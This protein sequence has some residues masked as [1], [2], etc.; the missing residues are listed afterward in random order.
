MVDLSSSSGPPKA[1]DAF[2]IHVP[3]SEPL[4]LT[5]RDVDQQAC[6]VLYA[7]PFA[8]A[9]FAKV[10]EICAPAVQPHVQPA[11]FATSAC[12]SYRAQWCA[13]NRSDCSADASLTG[14]AEYAA[15]CA[16]EAGA[17][18]PDAVT[19]ADAG[20]LG[21]DAGRARDAS[22]SSEAGAI[23]TGAKA[24]TGSKSGGCAMHAR[25]DASWL[26]LLAASLLR[27]RKRLA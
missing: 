14:C 16:P 3:L 24:P 13:D 12:P 17:S 11:P 8:S 1:S 25:V 22:A 27:R 2:L 23:D 9:Q 4:S 18:A 5:Q 20:Q 26:L 10:G 19:H 21:L 6:L 7:R 15:T